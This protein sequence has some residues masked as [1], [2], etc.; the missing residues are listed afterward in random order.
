MPDLYARAFGGQPPGDDDYVRSADEKTSIQARIRRHPSR[1]AAPG[2]PPR[3]EFEY[4]RGGA[5]VILGKTDLD[6]ETGHVPPAV[7]SD[8]DR[9]LR[10]VL[11]L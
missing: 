11:G 7:M 9:G 3:T 10:R 8:V 2:R 6:A 5:L 4:A 1:P